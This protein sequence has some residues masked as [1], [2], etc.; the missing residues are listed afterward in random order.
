MKV[1]DESKNYF[2]L[3]YVLVHFGIKFIFNSDYIKYFFACSDLYE[4]NEAVL[5]NINKD[6]SISDNM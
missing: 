6:Q 4:N 1:Y 2:I 5:I 3:K